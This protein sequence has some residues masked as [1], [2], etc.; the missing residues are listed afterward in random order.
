VPALEVIMTVVPQILIVDD[1][2]DALAVLSRP[3]LRRGY[4][5]TQTTSSKE[6]L[7]LVSIRPFDLV[8]LDLS[9][10]EP[11]GLEVLEYVRSRIPRLKIVV[12]SGFLQGTLIPVAK[13]FGAMAGIPKPIDSE[14]FISTVDGALSSN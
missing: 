2:V 9:M 3:L 13:L 7:G 12:I 1:D 14:L 11:D 5:V 10:P 8:I 6:A 4:V